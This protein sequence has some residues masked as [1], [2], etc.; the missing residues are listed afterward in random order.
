MTDQLAQQIMELVDEATAQLCPK[1]A[2]ETSGAAIATA[3]DAL[4]RVWKRRADCDFREGV[5]DCLTGRTLN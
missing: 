4:D 3:V 5:I 1:D 2:F